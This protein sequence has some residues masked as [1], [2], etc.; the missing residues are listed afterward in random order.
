MMA[1]GR[2]PEM[3]LNVVPV[4]CSYLILVK[5]SQVSI[6]GITDRQT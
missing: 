2:G 6:G 3:Y 1:V 5:Y 4:N